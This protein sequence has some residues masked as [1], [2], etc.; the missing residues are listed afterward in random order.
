MAYAASVGCYGGG[1]RIKCFD[2]IGAGGKEGLD[3]GPDIVIVD[4]GAVGI[5]VEGRCYGVAS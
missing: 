4:A 1:A 3:L 5:D 2:G